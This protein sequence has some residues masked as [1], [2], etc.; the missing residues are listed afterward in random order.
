VAA[1]KIYPHFDEIHTQR[2]AEWEV[3]ENKKESF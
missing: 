1:S 3:T 2:N